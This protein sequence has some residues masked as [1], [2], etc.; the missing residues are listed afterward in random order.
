MIMNATLVGPMG[1][2]LESIIRSP[3]LAK[4]ED[5]HCSFLPVIRYEEQEAN[6]SSHDDHGQK[7]QQL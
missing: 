2:V 3:H 4:S 6:A 7:K 5:D 1:L